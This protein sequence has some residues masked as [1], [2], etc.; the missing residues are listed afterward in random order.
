MNYT[1]SDLGINTSNQSTI[2][3]TTELLYDPIYNDIDLSNINFKYDEII[4]IDGSKDY[5]FYDKNIIRLRCKLITKNDK[6]FNQVI[7][8]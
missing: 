7:N 8:V 3:Q 2:S 1:L 6:E 4:N 5:K